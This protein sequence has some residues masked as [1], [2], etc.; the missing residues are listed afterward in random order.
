MIITRTK[1]I[2]WAVSV[3]RESKYIDFKRDFDTASAE[4]WCEVIKD[5]VAMANSGGGIILFGLE[6]DGIRSRMD[7][8]ALLAYDIADITNKIAKYTNYQFDEIEIVEIKRAGVVHAAFLI[9]A[10]EAPIIFTRPGT[11]EIADRKQKTAFGQGTIYFRHGA[12][13]EHGNHND[14]L[15]WREREIAKARKTWLGGIRK[16]IEAAPADTVTVFSSSEMTP[17]TN[18]R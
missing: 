15:K 14:L 17:N 7:H 13:S 18:P 3:P 4:A 9:S 12:K 2:E 8:A 6:N 11:Y 10:A 5:I 1:L 16:V